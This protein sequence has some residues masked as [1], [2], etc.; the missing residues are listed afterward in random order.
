LVRER[1][2]IAAEMSARPEGARDEAVYAVRYAGRHEQPERPAKLPDHDEVDFHGDGQ[3]TPERYDVRYAH[4]GTP[5]AASGPDR[6]L[7]GRPAPKDTVATAPSPGGAARAAP[8]CRVA[9][10][11]PWAGPAAPPV[12]HARA[13]GPAGRAR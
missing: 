7:T 2:Q 12:R 4:C 8:A 1:V 11:P 9:P 6:F 3:E 10:A 5:L 13:G